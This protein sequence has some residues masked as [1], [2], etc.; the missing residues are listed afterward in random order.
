MHYTYKLIYIYMHN[1]HTYI[2]I[3]I[4]VYDL[5]ISQYRLTVLEV[6]EKLNGCEVSELVVENGPPFFP[7]LS[8]S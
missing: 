4:H 3:C 7:P 8:I 6:T 2:C 5:Y 1:V